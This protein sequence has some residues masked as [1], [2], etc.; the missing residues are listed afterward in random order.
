MPT[1]HCTGV[2]VTEADIARMTA[3]HH[4]CLANAEDCVELLVKVC[5]HRLY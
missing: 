4:A 3:L 1:V 5:T 2:G